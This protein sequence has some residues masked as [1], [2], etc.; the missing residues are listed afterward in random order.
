M[1][2]LRKTMIAIFLVCM[3]I[4]F[5]VVA[6]AAGEKP[7]KLVGATMQPPQHVYYRT[8]QKFSEFLKERYKGP[9]EIDLHHSGDIGNES[10][11]TQFMPE[12]ISIDFCILAPSWMSVVDKGVGIMDAPFLWKDINQWERGLTE[13]VFGNIEKKLIDKG[14]RIVGYAGGG[15][16][17]LCLN[18][19]VYKIDD[20]PKVKM[21]VM[22]SPIQAKTFNATGIMAVPVDYLE[23]YNAINTGVVD[24]LENEASSY[25]ANKFYEVAPYIM[26]TTHTLTIRPLCF[27]EK[28]FKGYNK[29]LQE[30]ILDAS[31]EATKWAR[32]TEISEDKEIWEGLKNRGLVKILEFRDK[33]K[34]RERALPVIKK[35]AE[36]LAVADVLEKISNIQ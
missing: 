6:L 36:E 4:N 13:G 21:R 10:D 2:S 33:D 25:S 27:S 11:F 28:R 12:G 23:T 16:R 29:K 22:G 9:L 34:M 26:T 7:V 5:S 32:K 24:G 8:L 14:I 19:P 3:M 15:G 17:H 30:A 35:F 1:N 20:L 31:K 18:K